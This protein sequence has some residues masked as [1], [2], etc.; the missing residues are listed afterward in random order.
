MRGIDADQIDPGL[1]EA[2]AKPGH[3]DLAGEPGARLGAGPRIG[4][5]ASPTKPAR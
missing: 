3:H 5:L 2:G 1:V 4:D